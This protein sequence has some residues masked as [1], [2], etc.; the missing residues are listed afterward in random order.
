[1]VDVWMWWGSRVMVV[2]NVAF[3]KVA[4]FLLY[5]RRPGMLGQ[6][7]ATPERAF[8]GEVCIGRRKKRIE[9]EV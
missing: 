7:L 9:D 8:Q 6:D 2:V 4:V 1:M 5:V 3:L